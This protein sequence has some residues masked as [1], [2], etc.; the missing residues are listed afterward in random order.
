MLDDTVLLMLLF[1]R[2][3]SLNATVQMIL[4]IWYCSWWCCW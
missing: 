2:C 3:C 4:F 1:I